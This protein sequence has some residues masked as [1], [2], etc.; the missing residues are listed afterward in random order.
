MGQ[1][2]TR[3]HFAFRVDR[4]NQLGDHILD[5][6]AGIEDFTVA[7]ATFEAACRRWPGEPITLSRKV[8]FA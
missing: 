2:T 1:M 4:W 5:H 3:T 6:V 8:G 7:M